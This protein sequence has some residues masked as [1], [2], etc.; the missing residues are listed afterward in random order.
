[1]EELAA[2]LEAF[3]G[4]AR[5]EF[6]SIVRNPG[7]A[8]VFLEKP[9]HGTPALEVHLWRHHGFDLLLKLLGR[10]SFLRVPGH[11]GVQESNEACI[12]IVRIRIAEHFAEHVENP[13]AFG[14]DHD[15][16]RIG[17]L[18]RREARAHGDRTDI[19]GS[20]VGVCWLGDQALAIA[21]QPD[22]ESMIR[23]FL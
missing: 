7:S 10:Q 21:S 2:D 4:S 8:N 13:C 17:R 16:I 19:C 6:H 3:F 5:C 1:L 11:Q 22:E 23:D 9:L 18:R 14:V 20:E 15:F 12:G